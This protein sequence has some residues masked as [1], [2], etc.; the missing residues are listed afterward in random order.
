MTDVQA[1]YDALSEVYP[2]IASIPLREHATWPAT[3]ALVGDVAGERVLD[4]GCGTGE[5]TAALAADGAEV[6]GVD[7]SA[8]MLERARE[9]FGDGGFAADAATGPDDGVAAGD[10]SVSFHQA[11]LRE[12]LPF[13]DGAF[14]VALCQLALSHVADLDTVLAAFE[15]V[16]APGGR[17]VVAT[18]HPFHDF[19]VVDRLEYPRIEAGDT[20]EVDPTVSA[21]QHPPNYHRREPFR[22]QWSEDG[23]ESVYY[24]RSLSALTAALLDAGFVVDGIEEPEPDEA[25][26]ERWPDKYEEYVTQPPNVLCLRGRVVDR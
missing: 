24:R 25:F 11:D 9:R 1:Y 20:I 8:G 3:R 5:H 21:E 6:V 2:E 26:Q 14:D 13:D 12:G 18:H 16:L 22:I 19:Q 10:G 7:L 17:L 4:A 15:R 23:L